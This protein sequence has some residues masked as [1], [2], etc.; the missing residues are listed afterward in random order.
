M[1][2][3]S[4][5]LG[6]TEMYNYIKCMYWE[7]VHYLMVNVVTPVKSDMDVHP[8]QDWVDVAPR[9]YPSVPRRDAPWSRSQSVM[10]LTQRLSHKRPM[11]HEAGAPSMGTCKLHTE[12]RHMAEGL[13]ASH[14]YNNSRA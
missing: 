14:S 8:S 7:L 10:G 13:K 5:R 12:S 3:A 2:R 11:M 9:A 4:K 1:N 6:N